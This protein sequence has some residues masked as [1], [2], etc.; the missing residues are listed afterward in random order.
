VIEEKRKELIE[1]AEK[2]ELS[3]EEQKVLAGLIEYY[4]DTADRSESFIM[5]I[6]KAVS[7]IK[8]LFELAEG[9]EDNDKR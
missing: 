9:K 3:P 1:K 6:L 8:G 2:G 4:R 5:S 7:F